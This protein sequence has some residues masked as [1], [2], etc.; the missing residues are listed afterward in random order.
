M[1]GLDNSCYCSWAHIRMRAEGSSRRVEHRFDYIVY[2]F[3][4]VNVC[5]AYGVCDDGA[6]DCTRDHAGRNGDHVCDDLFL[7][8]P[9]MVWSQWN[10]IT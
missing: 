10:Q 1:V 2:N 3:A 8:R 6:N 7:P 9:W 5:A 4:Y